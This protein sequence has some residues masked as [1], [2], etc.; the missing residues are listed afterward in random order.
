VKIAGRAYW[1]WRAV[2]QNGIGLEEILQS[3]REKRAA[4]RLLLK[5][6]KR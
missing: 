1:L 5:L 6:M 2:D 3:K 4:K